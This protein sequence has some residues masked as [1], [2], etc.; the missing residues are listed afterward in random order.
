MSVRGCDLVTVVGAVRRSNG[1]A[2]NVRA[3]WRAARIVDVDRSA[4]HILAR[5]IRVERIEIKHL[6][7][8]ALASVLENRV[9]AARVEIVGERPGM[10]NVLWQRSYLR[11]CRAVAG[12]VPEE[13]KKSCG[14]NKIGTVESTRG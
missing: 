2:I 3:A 1:H 10:E 11:A 12:R 8:R 9:R 6:A 7:D 5:D 13:I 4:Q 14:N